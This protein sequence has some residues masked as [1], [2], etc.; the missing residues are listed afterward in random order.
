[1]L[2]PGEKSRNIPQYCYI[3]ENFRT[4]IRQGELKPGD[5]VPPEREL[6]KKFGVSRM[7]V[8]QALSDLVNEKLLYRKQGK[9]TFVKEFK[10]EPDISRLTSFTEDMTERGI[11]PASKLIYQKLGHLPPYAVKKWNLPRDERVI[12]TKRLRF[13]DGEPVGINTSHI[14]FYLC[15]G[16]IEENLEENS[17]KSILNSRYGLVFSLAEQTIEVSFARKDEATF[18]NILPRDPVF[19]VERATYLEDGRFLDFTINVFRSDKYKFHMKI[20]R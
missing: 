5:V 19:F 16:L 4:L 6:C 2:L 20:R 8:R 18:L 17:I 15:P 14:P 11:V 1:M 12:I 7:T 13:A 10:I 9:G 3:R